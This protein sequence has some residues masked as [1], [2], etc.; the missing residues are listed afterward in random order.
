VGSRPARARRAGPRGGIGWLLA[1]TALLCGLA[2]AG[3]LQQRAGARRA[4]GAGDVAAELRTGSPAPGAPAASP[5]DRQIERAEAALRR[6]PDRAQP[7]VELATGFMNKARES[8]DASYYARAEAAARKAAELAPDDYG[9]LRL[10]SWIYAGQHRFAEARAAAERAL[11]RDP[12]D[13]WNYGTLAD[14]LIELGEYDAASDAVQ[15]MVDLRPGMPAFV[16]VSYIRELYGETDGAIE[17]MQMAVD[18][19]AREPEPHAW[20]RTQL[21]HLLFDSGRLAEAELQYQ[22][23]L[24]VFANAHGALL[25]LGRV[26]AAQ[27]RNAEA[28]QAYRR[29]LAIAPTPDAAAEL[30]E[31]LVHLGRGAEASEPFALLAAIEQLNRAAGVPPDAQLALYAAEHGGADWSEALS[32]ALE[33]VKA[34]PNIRSYDVLAWAL[35]RSGRHAEALEASR[36][37]LRLGTRQARLH[38]R[39]GM[40]QAAL[41][42]DAE[43]AEA[44]RLALAINPHFHPAQ[45]LEA[46]RAL[47]RLA[48]AALPARSG[49]S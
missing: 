25:G 12:Q 40:I 32:R 42:H 27:G 13:P 3:W 35:H 9:A 44:L 8:A 11:A 15:K 31:L 33:Q 21:G 48:G 17:M 41:G 6:A 18:A 4:A 10:E 39:A 29:S 38:Y 34:L 30:G 43:A 26:W 14:A 7:Y 23:A 19:S 1:A 46:Q 16:R 5:A 28:L 45:A 49:G 2:V 22:S 36:Q 20:C 47:E 24:Q 37:A